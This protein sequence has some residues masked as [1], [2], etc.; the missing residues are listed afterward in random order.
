MPKKI[1][2]ILLS[3]AVFLLLSPVA[4]AQDI[5]NGTANDIRLK[6]K[7]V[8]EGSIITSTNE[9]YRQAQKDYDPYLFG[10]VSLNPALQLTDESDPDATPVISSGRARVRV[11][12]KNGAIKKGDYITSS[13]IAGVGQKATD[14]GTIIGTAEEDYSEKDPKKEGLILVTLNPH[15]AQVS[16]KVSANLFSAVKLGAVAAVQTPIGSLRY[17]I[18]GII[19]LLSFYFGFRFF[20]SLS[21]SGVEAVGRNPL[22]GKMIMAGVV[23]NTLITIFVMLFGVAIA[24]LILVL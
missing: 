23:I 8:K 3:L 16:S 21:K 1:T 14:N 7:N 22:A 13:E 18:A 17:M 10:V 4:L 9:G 20:A 12:T 24:Y 2:A 5:A 6:D 19:V 11:S 15:F